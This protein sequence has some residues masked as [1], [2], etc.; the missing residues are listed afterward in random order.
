MEEK[1]KV[2]AYNSALINVI[3][4]K[5]IET[6]LKSAY[7]NTLELIDNALSTGDR[8][9]KLGSGV[10]R[11]GFIDKVSDVAEK[12]PHFAPGTFD[13]GDLK[14]LVR[15]I[16]TL[17]NMVGTANAISRSLNDLLLIT[18]DAA[19]QESLLYY[20]AVREQSRRRIPGAETVFRMLDL[21]FR[22]GKR[23]DSEPTEAEV[24]R[25]FNALLHGHKDGKIVIEH[26]KP[27]KVGGKHIV[28][29]ETH[30]PKGAFKETEKGEIDE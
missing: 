15:Q 5:N 13:S 8:M 19:F 9:R 30:K 2:D 11:Y 23:K 27:H 25:D 14:A 12:F 20:T 26:E 21:F 17:R 28:V 18:G 22:R 4:L 29:D 3:S 7:G 6:P 1:K 24:E 16:E 10:R